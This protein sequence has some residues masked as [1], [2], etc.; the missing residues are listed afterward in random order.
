M[1]K[2]GSSARRGRGRPRNP[3]SP[4][5]DP[6]LIDARAIL[7]GIASD[8]LAPAHAR[9][10]A[11]RSLLTHAASAAA[12][13]LTPAQKLDQRMAELLRRH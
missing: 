7:A 13:E 12:A 2:R 11:A 4:L 9:V 8:P 5:A 1:T 6:A 10:S 3:P